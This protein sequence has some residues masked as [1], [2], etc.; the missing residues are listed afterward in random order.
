MLTYL[1][2]FVEAIFVYF[3]LTCAI[4]NA[5]IPDLLIVLVEYPEYVILIF[6]Q[7]TGN[8]NL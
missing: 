4:Y 6:K 5:L 2:L 8:T 1:Q 3:I 7:F